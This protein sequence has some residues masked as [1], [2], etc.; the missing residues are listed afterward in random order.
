MSHLKI[1]RRVF[2]GSAA[3]ALSLAAYPRFAMAADMPKRLEWQQFKVT[4]QFTSFY[5]AVQTM[6]ANTNPSDP[7]SWQY[8]VNVHVN[9]CP[10]KVPYFLAWH[11]G[12][13]WYFERQLQLVSKDNALT[14]PYWDYYTNPRLPSEFTDPASGNPL[15][16]SRVNTNVYNA[17]DLYPFST[18]VVNFQRGTVNSF[19]E[20]FETRPHNP[21]HNII[22]NVMSSMQSPQD[23]IFF[24][25]HCNVDRL[26]HAWSLP[27]GRTM[28]VSSA[29]YWTTDTPE[30]FVYAGGLTM[31]KVQTYSPRRA[32]TTTP[33]RSAYDYANTSRPTALPP[34]A[35]GGRI[36]RVQ[37]QGGQVLQIP[38]RGSFAA[39]PARDITADRR[40]IG[41]VKNVALQQQSV[42]ALVTAEAG[43]V[44]PLQ[45]VIT[46]TI[47]DFPDAQTT[48]LS[49]AVPA[50]ASASKA[51]VFRSVQVVLDNI[52]VTEAGASGGYFYY[53]YLN[54]PEKADIDT[55][56]Q[57]HFL[58]TLGAFEIAGAAHHGSVTLEYPATG[59][60][61]KIHGK[62]TRELV[63]S[64]LRVDGAIAPT[65]PVI[66][67]GEL[68]VE[69]STEAPFI[70]SKVGKPGPNDIPY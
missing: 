57:K 44:Q 69:L 64:L 63:I 21:V 68:R 22:G 23:P 20:T 13:L 59:A 16:V 46:T 52:S 6:R 38:P 67:I 70:K 66:L 10:H 15:Y 41:G 28:P 9:K 11:R 1:N 40:S 25:H 62:S 4:N 14:L 36:I 26:W 50:V 45:D 7:N 39:T 17:L 53:V 8:W 19:E 30:P 18:S 33:F 29:P 55:A 60:L 35:Q 54:L 32:G 58:G 48:S 43:A 12:Y 49:A 37:A 42:S 51:K 2:L 3:S 56:N 5:H 27:D 24:L 31:P 65:G 34:S 61:V 47:A